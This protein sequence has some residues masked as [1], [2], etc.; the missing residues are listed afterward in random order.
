MQFE[1]RFSV[2]TLYGDYYEN[3][4]T[5]QITDQTRSEK[6]WDDFV[7]KLCYKLQD[8][9]IYCDIMKVNVIASAYKMSDVCFNT[10]YEDQYFFK[11]YEDRETMLPLSLMMRVRSRDHYMDVE[12]RIT[13]P[14]D[15][16]KAKDKFL[17]SKVTAYGLI[18]SCL[19]RD[20][21]SGNIKVAFDKTNESA[22]V[23]DP[24]MGQK[25][26]EKYSNENSE[27]VNK[28]RQYFGE[29]EIDVMLQVE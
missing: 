8:K 19:S 27:A 18:G 23:H 5:I 15:E 4:Y 12:T 29:Q 1:D 17:V 3:N 20:R 6:Q 10:D 11:Q 14:D 26:I 13:S 2:Y 28:M 22:K 9:G 7:K 16:I 25:A 24:F 21:R